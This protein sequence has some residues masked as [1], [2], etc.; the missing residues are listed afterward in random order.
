[1][2]APTFSYTRKLSLTL[3]VTLLLAMLGAAFQF[4]YIEEQGEYE[5]AIAAIYFK[6]HGYSLEPVKAR[7]LATLALDRYGPTEFYRN[8]QDYEALFGEEP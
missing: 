7:H 3:I 6:R 1:M 4:Y 5:R 2:P 8:E